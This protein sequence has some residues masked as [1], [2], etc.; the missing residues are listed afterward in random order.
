[1]KDQILFND[2]KR[3]EIMLWVVAIALFMETLDITIISTSLPKI[4]ADFHV[5]PISLKLALTSYLISL[6]IFVPISGWCADKFG[7]RKVFAFSIFIFMLGSALCGISSNYISLIT[8]RIIQG[9]GGAL[10]MP[11]GRLTLLRKFPK[12]EFVNVSSY[13]AIPSL[14]GPAL[15]PMLGGFI[16][17]YMSWRWVFYINIPFGLLCLYLTL[18]NFENYKN[19]STPS[20]NILN[21]ILFGF[22]LAGL[23][24]GFDIIGENI[25]NFNIKFAIILT[26]FFGLTI[27]FIKAKR[28]SCELF[29]FNLFKVRTFKIAV[30]GNL[31]SRL[32]FG[33]MTF[34]LPLFFQ[35]GFNLTPFRSGLLFL[36]LALGMISMRLFVKNILKKFGYKRALIGNT[37]LLGLSIIGFSLINDKVSYTII[38]I[39]IFLHGALASLHF[40]CMNTL[41]FV[42][43]NNSIMSKGTSIACSVQQ[44]AMSLGVAVSALVL[45]YFS[46]KDFNYSINISGFHKTFIITGLITVFSTAIFCKLHKRDGQ[47]ASAHNLSC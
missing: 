4:A 3:K 7:S 41:S 6:A 42:D 34:L 18:K 39:L 30:L 5:D 19:E 28:N 45:R 26:S 44:L 47:M 22:S 10:M 16:T 35:L 17:T 37:F 1:M 27:A 20:F 36:P 31:C 40:G 2:K 9:I 46:E 11:V 24:F 21:F 43:L 15:G 25:L 32:G 13:V 33:G 14:I 29:D 38:V 12:E 8:A 23:S